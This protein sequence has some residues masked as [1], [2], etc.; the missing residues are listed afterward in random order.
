MEYTCKKFPFLEKEVSICDSQID[1]IICSEDSVCFSFFSGFTMLFSGRAIRSTIGSISLHQCCADDFT[2]Y[3]YRRKPTP[4][5]ARLLGKPITLQQLSDLLDNGKKKIEI[6]AELYDFNHLYWRGVL[7][8]HKKYG[9]SDTITIE[10]NGNF[11]VVYFCKIED[12]LREP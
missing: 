9:L 3:I 4:F 10:I 7:L 1:S 11:D 8:P 2:C 12:G 5:G 6:F